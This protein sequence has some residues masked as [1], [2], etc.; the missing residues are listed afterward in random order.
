MIL[1]LGGTTE[2]RKAVATLDKAG[3]TF[4]YS[5]RSDLQRVEAHNAVR[6]TG[7]LDAE[8]IVSFCWENDVRLI[9]DAAHPFASQLHQNVASAAETLSIPVVRFE[10]RFP[11]RNSSF[12]WCDDYADAIEKLRK[13]RV[14]SLLSLTG[15]QTISKL[16]DYW[17]SHHCIFRILDREESLAIAESNGFPHD[18]LVYYEEG[19]HIGR[20]LTKLSCDAILTKESGESGNFLEKTEDALKAG[21]KVFVVKRPTMPK[22]FITVTGEFGLRKAVEKLIPGFFELRSGFTTGTCATAA[23]TAALLAL[24]EGVI[25]TEAQVT[26]P[27]GEVM[28]LPI[29]SVS[30]TDE[31]SAGAS[32]IKDAGDDPDVTDGAEIEATVRLASHGEVRFFGGDGVGTVTL[33]GT[34]LDIGSPAINPVP[35]KMMTETLLKIYPGGCDVTISV[36]NGK[37]LAEKTFNPRIGIVGGIS[38]IGTSGIVMPFSN[39]A[40]MEAIQREME[41]AKAVGADR[42]VINSGARSEK[43]VK[44]LYPE[45]PAATFIHYGN[46]VGETLKI[47][48]ELQVKRLTVG[49]MLGKAVKLA[50]GHMDTHSHKVTMNRDFLSK[51]AKE[52]GCSPDATAAIARLNMARELWTDLSPEDADKF[53]PAILSLCKGQ[54][55]NYYKC[56]ELTMILITDSG[57]IAATI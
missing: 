40:F 57:N 43:C 50:E 16:S 36:P 32:V 3:K 23:A 5:T 10:R 52:A 45:L 17:R 44:S 54:C 41:V 39:E 19:G 34:G 42:V 46:A 20:L 9:V 29:N 35:R 13:A 7:A 15:V 14:R 1:I 37:E 51:V 24:T 33:P 6:I 47:A 12:I 25:M 22:G 55:Q 53:F 30:V 11:Q 26:I 8:A 28:S 48:D 27:N 56:G 4:Y 38:I 18:K 21:V 31:T 49:L 2:G